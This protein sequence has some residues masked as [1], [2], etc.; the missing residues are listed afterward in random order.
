MEKQERF[1][2]LRLDDR[3]IGDLRKLSEKLSLGRSATVRLALDELIAKYRP[4]HKGEITILKTE[5]FNNII[6]NL[7]NRIFELENPKGSVGSRVRKAGTTFAW[8][9]DKQ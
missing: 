6:G 9:G 2:S 1:I 4:G 7:G 8:E 5:L 3:L